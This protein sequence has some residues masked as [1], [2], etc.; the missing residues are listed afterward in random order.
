LESSLVPPGHGFQ[1]DGER[2]PELGVGNRVYTNNFDA[3]N[4]PD[5]NSLLWKSVELQPGLS[6]S[7]DV[8]F[9]V[10]PSVARHLSQGSIS[11]FNFSDADHDL[12]AAK[13]FAVLRLT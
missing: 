5:E 11:V 13:H 1:H 2:L 6:T 4:G 9:D 12:S 7:G 3:E 8:V 10:P